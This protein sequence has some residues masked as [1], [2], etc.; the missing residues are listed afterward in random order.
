MSNKWSQIPLELP[1][2]SE[3]KPTVWVLTY[4]VQGRFGGYYNGLFAVYVD[5]PTQQQLITAGVYNDV[6]VLTEIL[7][8][9]SS[10]SWSLK[11]TTPK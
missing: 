8:K 7:E 11:E 5:K 2:E 6:N 10:G 9:G 4:G 1:V 3:V